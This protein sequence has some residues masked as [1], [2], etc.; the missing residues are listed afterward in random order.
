MTDTTQA[1]TPQLPGC[2]TPVLR[3][4]PEGQTPTPAPDQFELFTSEPL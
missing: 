2:P 1:E 3:G 4:T